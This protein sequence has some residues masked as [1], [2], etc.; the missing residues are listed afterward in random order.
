MKVWMHAASGTGSSAHASEGLLL[1]RVRLHAS[2]R[3]DILSGISLDVPNGGFLSVLGAAGAGKS[4]LM[5]VLAGAA[6]GTAG[7]LT[8]AGADLAKLP[9]HRRGFG[10]VSQADALFPRLTLAQNIAYP[11]VLR[12]VGRAQRARMV[13]AAV[14][15]V[16]LEGAG[17][18][19]HLANAADRQRAW[20]ARATVFG[21]DLLLLDEPLS[22][23]PQEARALLIAALRRR[24]RWR[25]WTAAG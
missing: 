7:K 13:E 17:R 18:L 8:R 20:I 3:R 25:F 2:G 9:A 12:G 4:A 6:C 21:P 16:L 11:L 10:V 19:P 23:Q 22:H 14:E 24:T 5:A 1:E 15:S